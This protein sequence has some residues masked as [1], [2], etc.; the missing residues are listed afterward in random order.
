MI[1]VIG[2]IHGC[3]YTLKEL[4]KKVKLNYSVTEIYS[5]GDLID[6]GKFSYEVIEYII[7]KGIIS[8]V[9]NH[10]LMFYYYTNVPNNEIGNLWIFNG[11]E[12]TLASYSGKKEKMNEH[13]NFIKNL[14]F[15]I[16][17]PDC[18]ISHAGISSLLK[19]KL[20]ADPLLK[21]ENF[22]KIVKKYL[23]D[24]H[25]LIWNRDL[26]MNLGKLQIV[27]HTR[28]A[29]INYLQNNNTVYIDTSVYTGKKLSSIIIEEGKIIDSLSV[30]TIPQDIEKKYSI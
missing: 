17:L 5:V 11:N 28:Q 21:L 6:R 25:G 3:Y 9:G 30:Q 15:Y 16:N 14:P 19:K 1:A 2:D 12:T 4:V 7:E 24:E 10:E 20:T 13:L 29:Q 23:D 26:L 18:F 22:N 8:T 27:G